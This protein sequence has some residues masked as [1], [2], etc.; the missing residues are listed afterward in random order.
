MA[1]EEQGSPCTNNQKVML[2]RRGLEPKDYLVIKETYGALY[3]RNIHT[4][5]MKIINNCN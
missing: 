2:R 5:I 1:K 3:V 4:G